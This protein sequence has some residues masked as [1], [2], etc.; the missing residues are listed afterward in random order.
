MAALIRMGR[1]V[2]PFK[3]GPDFID[4]SLHR[5][6]C[7]TDSSNLDLWM[8]GE[9]FCH[10]CFVRESSRGDISI[11]EGVMG[12]FDG[13]VSSSASLAKALAVPLVLVLDTA[14]AAESV[15]AVAKGFEVYDPQ[16]RP[17]AIIL[18]R[19]ASTRHR[20]LVEEACRAHC[21]AEI[22][23][24][25]PRTEGFSLPS[26][27][28]G[29][30]MG[31]ESPLS[32]EAIDQLAT[33]VTEHIDLERLL[34]LTPMSQPSTPPPPGRKKEARIRLAV[35]R[36]AAFCFYY[37][38]NLELLEQAGA[39]L[40]FFSPLHDQHLPADIDGLYLGGGYPELY[41]KELSAN[42]GLLQQ[43]R[44]QA[45]NALPIYAEC[46]GFMYLSQGIRDGQGQFHPMA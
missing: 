31:E 6:I 9:K 43:I 37:P 12:A 40:L 46:G 27:H 23:G 24:V 20:S 5:M 26:R 7:G 42:H 28:L 32:P 14:S 4:P 11:I 16:I 36:D 21:Q 33:T 10:R 3:C 38:A 45:N 39:Q 19:I 18:N 22:I 13:G 15:A 41:G 30:H 29:L 8:S 35:A 25:L 44:E 1:R 17:V 2:V 34:T